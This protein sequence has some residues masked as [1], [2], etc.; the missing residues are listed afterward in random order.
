VPHVRPPSA[1]VDFAD[2][3][4]SRPT[5]RR[6]ESP[7]HELRADALSEVIPV[8][9]E[10]ERLARTGL[11]VV[12]YVSYDAAPAFDAA[13]AA[14]RESRLPLAWFGAFPEP[15][16]TGDDATGAPL[17][18]EQSLLMVESAG[19]PARYDAAVERIRE[20]IAN[21]DVYQ[22]NLTVPFAASTALAP[23]A[24][25]ERLRDA[26]H[27][28]YSVH[29][30]LGD[31]TIMSASP[32]LF[33]E[34]RGAI[35]RSRPM[36]GT[37]PRG[38]DPASDAASRRDLLDSEKDRAENVMIV[39][40][41]RND[42]GRIAHTGTVRVASLCEAERYPRVWQLTST[43]EAELDRATPLS[44]I[45]S[46][47]FPPASI[48]GAPKIRATR[49]IRELEGAP[50]GVYCGAIGMIRPGGDATFNVAI[51][52]AWSADGGGTLRLNAGG[53]VT[54]DSTP[55]GELAELHSKLSAFTLPALRPSLFETIRVEHGRP[56]RFERHLSRLSASADYFDLPFDPT[57][58][59]ACVDRAVAGLVKTPVARC[60]LLLSP[61]GV[62]SAEAEPFVDYGA[63]AAARRVAI[64]SKPVETADVRLYHKTTD[65][66]PYEL[67]AAAAGDAFD[68]VLWNERREATELTRGNLVAQLAGE[69]LTPPV[70]C[71]LLGGTLRAEL[72]ESGAIRE[73]TL[74]V[75]D[76]FGA[77]RL[78]FINSLRGWVPITLGD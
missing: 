9:D 46:A 28:R 61:D 32:E 60:R 70:A 68:V 39:D 6:F 30:G 11:W 54:I 76:L 27:G 33:F 24:L 58:A 20:H 48:T 37:A 77:E 72:L 16:S 31:I 3:D 50:R 22:V 19:S 40:V 26:Q 38:L 67:A 42:M 64:A 7:L 52:T 12:G 41:V 57:A 18:P 73:Q 13:F 2:D 62:L 45:F 23:E 75:E 44:R 51:R 5:R 49:I 14:R 15:A 21:G 66:E 10:A 55:S 43:V 47:L 4:R 65:R 36:K 69:R 74:T 17:A 78:W 29:L 59:E 56:I 63:S 1:I 8:L 34:R 35:L 25:Y 71:G 53:G